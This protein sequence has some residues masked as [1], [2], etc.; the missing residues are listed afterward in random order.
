[1]HFV[2]VYL[3]KKGSHQR[4]KSNVA[5]EAFQREMGILGEGIN[6]EVDKTLATK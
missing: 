5:A 4:C 3:K 2:G 6:L 1:V